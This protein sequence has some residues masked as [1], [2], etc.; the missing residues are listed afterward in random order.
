MYQ[1]IMNPISGRFVSIH[2]KIG[3]NIIKNYIINLSGGG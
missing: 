2:G 1:K 3:R